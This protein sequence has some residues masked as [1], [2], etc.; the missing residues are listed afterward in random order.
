[1][2]KRA[3]IGFAVFAVLC[4][5]LIPAW[6]ISKEGG[7]SASPESV[8]ADQEQGKMLF[9]INCGACHTLAKAGTD[10]VVG[11]NLDVLLGNASAD[12]NK[13]RVLN[14][15]DNGINGRMPKGIVAGQEA[16]MVADFVAAN[17]GK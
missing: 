3:Y 9:Q 8:P 1:M 10:G 12:A 17:A 6:A 2:S 4:A 14:A 7:E 5:V 11:P 13:Q 15:V 16:Q